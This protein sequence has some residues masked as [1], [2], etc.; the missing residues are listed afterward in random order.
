MWLLPPRRLQGIA[1]RWSFLAWFWAAVVT[2]LLL[3]Q[4]APAASSQT[5][6]EPAQAASTPT[7][8]SQENSSGG[9]NPAGETVGVEPQPVSP[10]NYE[11]ARRAAFNRVEDYPTK[12]LPSTAN[13]RPTG[14]WMGRLILPSAEEATQTPGDWVWLEVW[15]APIAEPNLL[16]QKVKLTWTPGSEAETAAQALTQPVQLSEQAEQAAARGIVVPLRLD[17]R[18]AVGPLQSLAGAHP[19]D[20]VTVRLDSAKRILDGTPLLHITQEP[21]QVTGREYALVKLLELDA[22]VKKPLPTACPGQPPCPSEYFKVQHYNF[23]T[24]EFDGDEETVRIPQQPRL[25]RD[26][27]ASSIRNLADSPAGVAGW[28]IY[29][30]RDAEGVFTVQALKPRALFQLTPDSVALGQEAGRT[31]I[32]KQ[33]WL[34]TPE[35]KGTLQRVLISPN[36]S[37]EEAVSAWREG[38]AALVLHLLGG[39][40]GGVAEDTAARV[41]TVAGHFDYGLARVVREPFTQELQ[42]DVRYQPLYG[43]NSSGLTPGTHDWSEWMGDLQRG[44]LGQRPAADVIVRLSGFVEPLLL[45][46]TEVSLGREL[47]AQLQVLAAR[48]RVGDGTGLTTLN[49]AASLSDASQA[50]YLALKQIQQRAAN[51]LMATWLRQNPQAPQAQHTSQLLQLQAAVRSTLEPYGTVRDETG[52]ASLIGIEGRIRLGSLLSW[53]AVLPRRG[54]DDLSR[55]FMQ[56]GASLWFLRSNVVGGVDPALVPTAPTLL[57]GELPPLATALRRL[58]DATAWQPWK[59]AGVIAGALLLYGAIALPYGFKSNFLKPYA[60]VRNPLRLGV[61]LLLLML[62]PALIEELLF[63]VLLLPHPLEALPIGRWLLW[64]ALSLG[65]FVAYHF[66]SASTYYPAGKPTFFDRRFVLLAAWLGFVLTL[67]YR[68]SGSLWAVATIH[69]VVVAL[70]L[71]AFGGLPRLQ[72]KLNQRPGRGK[73]TGPKRQFN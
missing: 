59:D 47:Q 14:E 18:A 48:Y 1:F 10:S 4:A 26:R 32:D 58:A 5:P 52:Q 49:P 64:A 42:F 72:G 36:G 20:D 16:G 21:V 8:E 7:V 25:E 43:H 6:A 37:A 69:W 38:D 46:G 33:N 31:Y 55:I 19:Q 28:Y 57:L 56:Q 50:L 51:P 23:M 73:S 39:M 11:L 45:S 60:A 70:W 53:R 29:G 12:S 30:A 54:Q 41:G 24:G 61:N 66:V 15:N 27:F 34:N 67:A 44:W 22:E 71:Y 65:L 63:R 3:V 9:S 40:L 17:G 2:V 35:R 68:L 13:Y 62:V